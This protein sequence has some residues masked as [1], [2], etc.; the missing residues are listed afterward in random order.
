MQTETAGAEVN[1]IAP[2]EHHV[3]ATATTAA[4]SARQFRIFKECQ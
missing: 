4:Q 3:L 1:S 2:A